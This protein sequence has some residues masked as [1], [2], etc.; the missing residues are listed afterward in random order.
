MDV[1][2]DALS[3]NF[4]VALLDSLER[5]A[6]QMTIQEVCNRNRYVY[7]RWDLEFLC[8]LLLLDLAWWH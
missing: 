6:S 7:S 8:L 3:P 2:W 4:Q 1:A 5:T